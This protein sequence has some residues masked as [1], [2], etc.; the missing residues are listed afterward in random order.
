MYKLKLSKIKFLVFVSF[1]LFSLNSYG[2]QKDSLEY[3]LDEL[4][5]SGTRLPI[6]DSKSARIVKIINASDIAKLPVKTLND[7]LKYSVG[8]DVRQRGAMG[9]Q[10]D[11][12]IRGGRY[13][14]VAILLNGINITDPHTGHNSFSLAVNLDDIER[15]ELIEGPASRLYGVSSLL[16]AVNIIT[17]K[18][19]SSE[20]SSSLEY[21]SF[22]SSYLSSRLQ[23]ANNN[24]FISVSASMAGSDGYSKNA[25]GWNNAD[26]K[27]YQFYS[28]AAKNFSWIDVYAQFAYSSKAFGAN[29]FYGASSDDQFEKTDKI[30]ASVSSVSKDFFHINPNIYII[31]TKDRFDYLRRSKYINYHSTTVLGANISSWIKTFLG[32]SSA[33]LEFRSESILSTKI[34][35]P[36][37]APIPV[38]NTDSLY[39]KGIS[40]DNIAFYLEHSFVHKDFS[41]SA[42][43]SAINNIGSKEAF[44]IYPG[45]NMSYKIY[46]ALRLYASVNTSYSSPNFVDLGYNDTEHKANLNL[47]N[48]KMLSYDLAFK[49]EGAGLYLSATTFVQQGRD[50]IDWQRDLSRNEMF[51][52]VRQYDKLSTIGVE[53][54]SK[55]YPYKYS[56]R[57]LGWWKS[58][59][60]SY[61]Y[62]YKDKA[63]DANMESMYL[64]TYL[65]HK[66]IVE[67]N[68]AY[69]NFDLSISYNLKA[70][71]S[72][73]GEYEKAEKSF[74]IKEYKPYSLLNLR[75]SWK[76]AQY[77]IYTE[78][79]NM[80]NTRYFDYG[81]IPQPP[82]N[83][84]L[85]LK[86]NLSK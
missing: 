3:R 9:S 16:G 20:L 34:G 17:K 67:S 6:R 55:I 60:V 29:T 32:K 81:D 59:N 12:S 25:K 61:M 18:N 43:L 21:G 50:L 42:G 36:L 48:E 15:V 52:K 74:V 40:R 45:I 75:L 39:S 31:N 86:Y 82:F 30:F 13:S 72:S 26:Y 28:Q 49:Y 35:Y 79:L 57:F 84:R 14:A 38:M 63:P 33:K 7:L 66:F 23:L 68:F 37:D 46:S 41:M 27:I 10:T 62:L 2:Q 53:F 5:F 83:F 1:F 78:F 4:T 65:R 56:S 47:K 22:A 77:T 70:R 71:Q 64:L 76:N 54:N 80:T 58:L 73:Y 24:S 8:V 69:R 11:V 51:A 19:K 44:R 85:G